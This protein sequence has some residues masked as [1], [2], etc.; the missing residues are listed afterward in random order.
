MLGLSSANGLHSKT[1]AWRAFG[2][3]LVFDLSY[4]LVLQA[5]IERL[6]I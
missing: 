3:L 4:L 1:Q 6:W 2:G 5:Y